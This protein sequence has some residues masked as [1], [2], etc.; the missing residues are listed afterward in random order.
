MAENPGP[1]ILGVLLATVVG[2]AGALAYKSGA[3]HSA[4]P[5]NELLSRDP[6]PPVIY[7]RSFQDDP[8]AAQG[9]ALPHQSLG[10]L[11]F[12]NSEEQQLASVASE[13]GPFIAV[14]KPGEPLPQI[15][16]ARMYLKNAE[17]QPRVL[18][19]MQSARLV[20]LRAGRTEGLW[21]EVAT[22]VKT[23]KPER[24]VFLLPYN[25]AQYEVFRQRAESF[26]PCR[27]PG[28]KKPQIRLGTIQGILYF[29]PDWTAHFQE[30]KRLK[31]GSFQPLARIYK[32]A[33][34]PVFKQLNIPWKHPGYWHVL[35]LLLLP[36]LAT[37]LVMGLLALL[38]K[39]SR[40]FH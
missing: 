4:R 39:L 6:R 2:C 27:L 34:Q 23:V 22:A 3:Q 19:L 29:E 31:V 8:V 5:A 26:L 30:L 28:Y 25:A 33:F 17:W 35:L 40:I 1:R 12:T 18:Q 11:Q 10:F 16:A 36:F 13:I 24:L 14:G 21:W 15:G 7:L 37:F 38:V 9:I 20:L 32:F